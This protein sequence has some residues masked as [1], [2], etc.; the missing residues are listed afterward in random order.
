MS[1]GFWKRNEKVVMTLLLLILAPTFAAT[2]AMFFFFGE[3]QVLRSDA[4]EVFGNTLTVQDRTIAQKE[5]REISQVMAKRSYGPFYRQQTL[6]TLEDYIVLRGM[7]DRLGV[8]VGET[9]KQEALR[10]AALDILQWYRVVNRPGMDLMDQA[11]VS[12]ALMEE[13]TNE[14][15]NPDEYRAALRSEELGPRFT[16]E[17]FEAAVVRLARLAEVQGVV[18][19]MAIAPE[20]EIY[21]DYVSQNEKRAVD[22]VQVPSTRFDA[23]ATTLVDDPYLREYFANNLQRYRRQP[24]ARLLVAKADRQQFELADYQPTIEEIQARYDAD[25]AT[26]YRQPR[27]AGWEPPEGYDPAVDDYRP[28]VDVIGAVEKSLKDEFAEKTERE[29]L[30]AALT[31]AA[32]L[33]D[34]GVDFTLEELFPE[35]ER[36]RIIFDEVDWFTRTG[37]YSIDERFRNP[38]EMT[39]VLFNDVDPNRKGEMSA[40]PLKNNSGMF[41]YRI[42][43]FEEARDK[44]FEEALDDGGVVR[45]AERQKA[46]ELTEEFLAEAVAKIRAGEM[47]LE[48]WAAAENYTV[49]SG[50]EPVNLR[51]VQLKFDGRQVP[52]GFNVIQ[53]VFA[54]TTEPGDITDPV[55]PAGGVNVFIAKLT[56]LVP[57]SMDQWNTQS[58]GLENMVLGQHRSAMATAFSTGL[59]EIANIR[60]PRAPEQDEESG[61]G[62]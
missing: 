62:S 59:H 33:K 7:A 24:S 17:D 6:M 16:V 51:G 45:D 28:L 46:K 20:V 47:T 9:Q 4:M 57:P 55:V 22:F 1:A 49:Q 36:G 19:S 27:P 5:L 11:A 34:Q 54:S 21:N 25:K 10:R 61:E 31:K 2:G 3:R 60:Y 38:A 39:A 14:V 42:D 35:E 15:F 56:E 18:N 37:S 12:A 8:R 52:F 30:D 43:G 50:D 58:V 26:R 32:G 44:T 29:L 48:E 53:E 40:V 41:I 13:S 23:Q